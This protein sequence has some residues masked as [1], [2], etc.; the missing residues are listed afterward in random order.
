MGDSIAIKHCYASQMT[1]DALHQLA[2]FR[3]EM[4]YHRLGWDVTVRDGMETDRYDDLNPVYVIA[5][6]AD[7]TIRSC[8]RL[9]PT[10]GSYM[11]PDIFP[12]LLRGEPAPVSESVWEFSRLAVIPEGA[13]DN[14]QAGWH[15]LTFETIRRGI[16]F[17]CDNGITEYVIVTTLAMER[18]LH[19]MG[20]CTRRFG[21]GKSQMVGKVR[22]VASWLH[23]NAQTIQAMRV[24]RRT[25]AWQRA[26]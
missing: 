14:L 7:D 23:I 5:R 12:Q 10:T 3:A 21:D 2:R 24:V 19:R 1:T 17:A 9:L 15:P 13:T 18:L 6:G 22:C 25:A 16:Q 4:F 20:I 26:A 11:L 8:A